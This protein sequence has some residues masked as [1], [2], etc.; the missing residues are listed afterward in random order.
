MF[1]MSSYSNY[2]NGYSNPFARTSYG[3]IR[4][5]MF[6]SRSLF[7]NKYSFKHKR[8]FSRRHGLQHNI[9]ANS[10]VNMNGINLMTANARLGNKNTSF[11]GINNPFTGTKIA[12]IAK[13]NGALNFSKTMISGDDIKSIQQKT[14]KINSP[15][16]R[17][18][19]TNTRVEDSE[20]IYN[21]KRTRGQ[22]WVA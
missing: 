15:F 10:N 21:I 16:F 5:S 20:K 18:T 8:H 4:S 3:F 7:G 6:T 1:A 19:Q 12:Q 9:F 14:T 17:G 11:T 13:N 22:S 2:F